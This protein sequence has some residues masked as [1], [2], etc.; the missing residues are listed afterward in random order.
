MVA[1]SWDLGGDEQIGTASFYAVCSTK[2]VHFSNLVWCKTSSCTE[3][4]FHDLLVVAVY[5]LCSLA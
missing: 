4:V 1:N 5:I 2:W 3:E